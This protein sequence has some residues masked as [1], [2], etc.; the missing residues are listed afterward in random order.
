MI[1]LRKFF[2][3]MF[4]KEKFENVSGLRLDLVHTLSVEKIN[5]MTYIQQQCLPIFLSQHFPKSS[6]ILAETGS[7][8]TLCYLL[9][10]INLIMSSKQTQNHVPKALILTFSRELA[11]QVVLDIK[12]L[13]PLNSI[14]V[15]RAGSINYNNNKTKNVDVSNNEK[16]LCEDALNSSKNYVDFNKTDIVVSTPT[17]LDLLISYKRIKNM[18]PYFLVVD[19]ADVLLDKDQNHKKAIRNILAALSSN[20]QKIILATASFD[21]KI[22]KSN[23]KGILGEYMKNPKIFRN[24]N[25]MKI[26]ELTEHFVIE[27]DS[28]SL[29]EKLET[30]LKVLLSTE[31]EKY[32][33]FC[34]SNKDVERVL[35]F[36]IQ[37]DISA[38]SLCASDSE[39]KRLKSMMFFRIGQ[40]SV[41]ITSD[42]TNRGLHFSFDPCV[43]QFSCATNAT[44]LLHRFGRTGRLGRKGTVI[45]FITKEDMP[46][47]SSFQEIC[48]NNLKL[49]TIISRKRSFSKKLK[50]D[51]KD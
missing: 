44:A 10:I 15:L 30:L 5:T 24:E 12:K 1:P 16:N 38:D 27:V 21:P 49:D 22:E 9:P 31:Q 6:L 26:S 43:I 2:C 33:V 4:C 37:N 48:T 19:E 14:S 34:Q 40:L 47:L 42:A 3:R 50:K 20:P 36:C 41:L 17:Q 13:D 32:L 29:E 25:Y 45:S 23:F 46:L 18:N 51:N 11:V 8:K 35:E 39:E 28:L 7:G